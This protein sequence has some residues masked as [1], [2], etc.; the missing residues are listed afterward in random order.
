MLGLLPVGVRT[1]ESSSD[2]VHLIDTNCVAFKNGAAKK[3]RRR[4]ISFWLGVQGTKGH[5]D[6]HED[7]TASPSPSSPG[8]AEEPEDFWVLSVLVVENKHIL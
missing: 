7:V 5:S 3:K 6:L 4:E 1:I 2:V 8:C